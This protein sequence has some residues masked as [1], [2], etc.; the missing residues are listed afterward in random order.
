MA[1]LANDST[2]VFIKHQEEHTATE[3]QT[4]FNLTKGSY[5]INTIE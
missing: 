3:N 4:I 1:G 2:Y 5:Q